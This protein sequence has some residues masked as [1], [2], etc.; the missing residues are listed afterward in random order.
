MELILKKDVENLGFADDIVEVKNGYGRNFLIPQGV[1]VLATASAKKVLAENLKQRAY[2]E[3][4]QVADAQEQA[5]KVAGLNIKLTAKS[6]AGNKL[7]GS[8]SNADLSEALAKE[9]ITVEKKFITI[10][11]GTI[12]RLGA[13]E[14]SI[15]FHRS[16]VNKVNF[17]IIAEKS[18]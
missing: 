8:I 18:A 9:G 6:G 7:F 17:E 10:A 16:V 2:K 14:A 15:R 3:Q 13:Y 1:A 4:K 11:G 5:Q 12:K